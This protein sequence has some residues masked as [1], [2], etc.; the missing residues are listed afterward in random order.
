MYTACMGCVWGVYGPGVCNVYRVRKG[1]CNVYGVCMGC[2]LGVYSL[3]GVCR[4]VYGPGVCNVY[5]GCAFSQM[6]T[7][8][9]SSR[10]QSVRK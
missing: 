3:H 6:G 1:V 4:G 7:L 5:A 2:V 9:F 8:S 10:F